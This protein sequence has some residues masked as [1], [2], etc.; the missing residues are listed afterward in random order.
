M[1]FFIDLRY[2]PYILFFI[3]FYMIINASLTLIWFVSAE[4]VKEKTFAN[5]E[6]I[7]KNGYT[8]TTNSC[9]MTTYY[10]IYNNWLQKSFFCPIVLLNVN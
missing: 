5:A 2:S 10:Y 1:N 8:V 4:Y 6:K 9:N 3:L 7:Q